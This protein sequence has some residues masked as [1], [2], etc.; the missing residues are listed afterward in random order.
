MT[1]TVILKYEDMDL[2]SRYIAQRAGI[3]DEMLIEKR[4]N[5]SSAGADKSRSD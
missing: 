4:V 2:D 3:M 1:V 5:P